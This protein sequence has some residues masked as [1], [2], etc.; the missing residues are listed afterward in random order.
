RET[1][2]FYPRSPY[3]V[4]KIYAYWAT[5]NYREAYGIHATNGILFN[6][7]SPLRGETF[8]TRKITRSV[9][10]IVHGLDQQIF[11]GNLNAKRD[12]GHA[13][14]Y[15][16]AMWRI[17]QA[18][19]PEDYVL[20]TGRTTSVRD[21]LKLSFGN[22]G[23]D[24]A[25]E[26]VDEKEVGFCKKSGKELVKIDPYYFRPTEVDLLLGDA[27]KAKDQ[28]GW[29]AKISVE[30]LCKEM[31][32]ADLYRVERELSAKGNRA[33]TAEEH[34]QNGTLSTLYKSLNSFQ[35]TQIY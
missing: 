25:F 24:L 11:I 13:K 21:F 2:P 34:V 35:E 6:H 7:E 16:E 33:P 9:A 26:G 19:T 20:A 32:A 4:A 22:V 17:V 30:D 15:V 23:I 28:L 14:E 31:V 5:V 12:W 29:E 27:S 1:T 8:V 18:E 10:R 3:A